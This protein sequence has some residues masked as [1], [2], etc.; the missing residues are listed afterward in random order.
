MRHVWGVVVAGGT[1]NRF[2]AAKQ[3]AL[4]GGRPVV[5]WSVTACRE[6]VGHV[7]LVLPDGMTD[8]DFGADIVVAGG[9]SRAASVRC[10][11]AAVPQDAAVVVVH[12]AAR[13]FASPDLFRQVVKALDTP[14]VHG[15]VC[16]IPVADTLKRVGASV[17]APDLADVVV[18][19]LDRAALVRVQTPQAFTA[20][21]LRQAH[22]GSPEATDDAALVEA[23]GATVQVVPGDPRNL[24]LTDPGD[25]SY[26]QHLLEA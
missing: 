3:F 10:G 1:G 19:T 16:G 8:R 22:A 17:A 9:P 7:V 13:P 14:G 18:E 12:D 11:L 2:G 23:M 4:L 20:A 5:E 21:V 26:L 15:A 24:K 6:A 25:L